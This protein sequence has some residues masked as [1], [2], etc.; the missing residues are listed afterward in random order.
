MTL[1]DNRGVGK[2]D[3]HTGKDNESFLRCKIKLEPSI[4]SIFPEPEKVLAWAEDQE[5][6]VTMDR[7]RAAFGTGMAEPVETWKRNHLKCT[8]CCRIHL[9]EN[10][11]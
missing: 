1:I 3:K 5:F 2:P 8:E 7:A 11:L 9:R 10:L 4:F 6:T